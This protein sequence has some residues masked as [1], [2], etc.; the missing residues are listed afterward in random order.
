MRRALF[1]DRDGVICR[2]VKYEYGWD[3]P[4]TPGDVRLVEGITGIINWANHNNI[5]VVEIS[6][7]PSVARGKMS[8]KISDAIEKSVDQLLRGQ[9][10][11]IDYVYVCPHHP[12]GVVAELTGEC[13]C[14]KPKPGLLIRAARELGIDLGDS[15]FLGDKAGDVEAGE[16]AGCKTILYLHGDDLP[17]K[18]EE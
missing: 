9:G 12:K 5:L 6:N 17:E 4:Q 10:A 1:I 14:R 15:F 2:M 18:G 8:Q 3:S 7:Q 16:A 11:K 13:D